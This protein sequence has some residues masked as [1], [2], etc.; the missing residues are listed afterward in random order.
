VALKTCLDKLAKVVLDQPGSVHMPRIGT[1]Q[2]RGDWSVIAELIDVALIKKNIE[3][4]AY[5]LPSSPPI[6][7]NKLGM[8]DLFSSFR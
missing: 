1:G 4:T 5:D 3:V 8:P 7:D 6:P 2:A